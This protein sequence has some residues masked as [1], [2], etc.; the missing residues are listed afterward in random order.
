LEGL[1]A[2]AR[3]APRDRR[4]RRRGP[5]VKGLTVRQPHAAEIAAGRKRIENRSWPPLRG[6]TGPLVIQAGVRYDGEAARHMPRG[7]LAVVRSVAAHPN[8]ACRDDAE[9]RQWPD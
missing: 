4:Q 6:F 8:D 7:A 9:F 3:A 1:G 2:R 5:R